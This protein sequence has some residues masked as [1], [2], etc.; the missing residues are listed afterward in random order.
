MSLDIHSP[1]HQ[2]RL[3]E[4]D[5]QDAID[6]PDGGDYGDVEMAGIWMLVAALSI[7]VIAALSVL[8]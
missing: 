2:R 6:L 5:E 1:E 8:L 7:V 4:A 3:R